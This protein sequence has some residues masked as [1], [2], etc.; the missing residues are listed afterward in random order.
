MKGKIFLLIMTG[1]FI[2]AFAGNVSAVDGLD[3][4]HVMRI[5]SISVEPDQV[6]VGGEGVL[7][8]KLKNLGNYYVSDVRVRV[9]LPPEI[10]FINDISRKKIPR[11][12]AG[13]SAEVEYNIMILPD[14]SEGIVNSNVTIDY[15]S[16][17]KSSDSVTDFGTAQQDVDE[18]GIII[19]NIPKI[20][21]QVD[22]TGVYKGKNLG[23]VSIKFINNDLGDVKFLTVELM[24][25]EDYKI[26]SANREYVGDLDSDDFDSV[27]FKINLKSKA[28]E[29][30]LPLKISYKDSM[31]I[32]YVEEINV[33][34]EMMSAKE[35][36]M[37]SGNTTN[38]VIVVV[39]VVGV[40]YWYYRRRKKK[41]AKKNF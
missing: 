11:I 20:F 15:L 10:A 27:D 41:K 32:D 37:S 12:E 17:I 33:P 14:A 23:E 19:K 6:G 22:S 35:L 40:G 16:H 21:A 39:I 7:K 29:V 31:N 9:D 25:S 38:I 30:N 34:L 28:K 24:E 3:F 8:L 26:I 13:A 5:E 18:F 4:G 36:G 2:I 1:I